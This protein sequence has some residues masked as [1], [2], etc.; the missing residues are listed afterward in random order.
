[1]RRTPIN[2]SRESMQGKTI[3]YIVPQGKSSRKLKLRREGTGRKKKVIKRSGSEV[4][5]KLKRKLKQK[6]NFKIQV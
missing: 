1:M 2:S 3:I 6:F 4:E 5:V